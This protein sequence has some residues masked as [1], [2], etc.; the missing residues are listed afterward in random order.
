LDLGIVDEFLKRDLKIF[1]PTR[2][3]AEIESSK[4]FAKEFMA[5]NDIPTAAFQVF[6]GESEAIAYLNEQ[7][8]KY[9]LVV[10]A[11]GLAAGKGVFVCGSREQAREA[12]EKIM[13]DK[14]FGSSGD[15]VIIEE[16]LVGTEVSFTA[17]SDGSRLAAWPTSQD[18]KRAF[19]GDDGPNTGGMGC[20]SPSAY[21]DSEIFKEILHKIMNP[22]IAAMGKEGRPYR[23]IL[24]GGIMLTKE[25]PVVLEF[26]CRLGDPETEALLPRMKSDIVPVL[27][28]AADG[29]LTAEPIEWHG[30]AA[31]TVI[32][33]SGGYPGSYQKGK[34]I[35]G[36]DNLSDIDGTMVFHCGTRRSAGSKLETAG[37]RVLAVTGLAPTLKEAAQR[38]YDAAAKISFEKMHC[39]KDIA[40][41]AIETVGRRKEAEA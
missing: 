9:P 10:K 20:Y 37:G 36:L 39:R 1:G 30:G 40:A 25:G 5:R 29:S 3:A 23:G 21:V 4:V 2:S 38:S 14:A 31:V 13:A 6:R 18:F 32:L 26:N 7:T 34:T 12:V 19:D 35:D 24:Y 17:I 16:C 33:A 41:E 15:A 22:T 27:M 28:A 11:D 8:T